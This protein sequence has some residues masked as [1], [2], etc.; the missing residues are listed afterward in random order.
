MASHCSAVMPQ[1]LSSTCP[2][3]PPN[4][5]HSRHDRFQIE[6]S[7]L[8]YLKSRQIGWKNQQQQFLFMYSLILHLRPISVKTA[9][10]LPLVPRS[11]AF[12]RQL[13][14]KTQRDR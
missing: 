6:A 2:P 3:N 13:M 7:F 8:L 4:G 12:K 11:A 9:M 5:A 1:V 10:M 14:T